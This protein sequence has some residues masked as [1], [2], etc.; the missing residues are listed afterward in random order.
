ME[1]GEGNRMA[2]LDYEHDAHVSEVPAGVR[3]V[4]VGVIPEVCSIS[5]E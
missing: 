5:S 2:C 3:V 4:P 1:D